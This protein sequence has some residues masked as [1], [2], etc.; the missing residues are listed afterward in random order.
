[1][2]VTVHHNVR[3][4]VFRADPGIFHQSYLICFLNLRCDISAEEFRYEAVAVVHNDLSLSTLQDLKGLKSCHT[5]V[6]RNVGYK[7]PITKVSRHFD[8]CI[9]WYTASCRLELT[10]RSFERVS[11]RC[12]PRFLF[13]FGGDGLVLRVYVSYFIFSKFRYGKHV[14]NT[15]VS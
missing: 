5:G 2:T 14:I 6:G 8:T 4:C 7:I 11:C 15:T 9:F 10:Q 13:C 3:N 1:M 12:E